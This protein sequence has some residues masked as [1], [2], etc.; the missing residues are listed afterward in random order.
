VTARGAV[1][2]RGNGGD[3]HVSSAAI[4]LQMIRKSTYSGS[5]LPVLVKWE[6]LTHKEIFSSQPQIKN[7]ILI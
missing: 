2:A 7:Y 5:F 4:N 3:M 1:R 6:F